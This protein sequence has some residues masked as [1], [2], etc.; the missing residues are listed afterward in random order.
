MQISWHGF[1]CFELQIKTLQGEVQ[2]L[3][4]PYQNTTGLKLSRTLEADILLVS[5]PGEDANNTSAVSGDP[6][7]ISCPGEYEVK[8]VFAFVIPTRIDLLDDKKKSH[9]VENLITRFEVG[10]LRIGHLGALNRV[11]TEEELDRLSHIDILMVPVGGGR[12]LSPKMAVEV[13]G[14]IEPRVVIPMTHALEGINEPLESVEA[15]CKQLGSSRREDMNKYKVVK[16]DL[17]SEDILIVNLS[18]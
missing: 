2:V 18:R 10:G 4:D 5:H 9:S 7:L 8:G 11:L 16:K 14:Q 17:P 1:S 12:V 13:V 15:F 6:F 3:I